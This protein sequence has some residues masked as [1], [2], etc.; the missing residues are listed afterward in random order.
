MFE[1][2][3]YIY[4]LYIYR[5]FSFCIF[6]KYPQMTLQD[7]ILY[8]SQEPATS[9]LRI[10]AGKGLKRQ[11][12]KD[13]SAWKC[14][15]RWPPS[16]WFFSTIYCL[17]MFIYQDVLFLFG[18]KTTN[19]LPRTVPCT[20]LSR[21]TGPFMIACNIWSIFSWVSLTQIPF[22]SRKNSRANWSRKLSIWSCHR[23][24]ISISKNWAI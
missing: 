8:M 3:I 11:G 24:S 14:S 23:I 7:V 2:R 6:Q 10:S 22:L 17:N 12:M 20:T 5:C 18:L 21:A 1:I 15:T 4:S 13:S 19:K 9:V 16:I